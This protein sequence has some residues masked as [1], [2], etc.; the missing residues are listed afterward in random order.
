M[1]LSDIVTEVELAVN[2]STFT[3]DMLTGYINDTYREVV[4]RCLVPD[5]KRV[6]VVTT[7]NNAYVSL[8]TLKSGFSGVLSRVY[9]S[10][11][12]SLR[13]FNKLEFL[14]DLNGNLTTSG[15]LA[16]VALEGNTLWYADIPSI[17]EVLTVI[18]Y[19]LPDLLVNDNDVP[20]Y[21]PDFLHRQIL[22][23]GA[24]AIA[25]DYIEGGIEG[26]KVN[27]RSRLLSMESGVVKFREWLGKNRKHYI[28]T[29]GDNSIG[30]NVLVHGVPFW[31]YL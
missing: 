19:A 8:S 16:A 21:I 25:W 7:T 23:N 24:A 3:S 1:V 26:L 5:L 2:D 12:N 15:E 10:D 4:G 18:Y 30:F 13:I 22:V 20:S 31:R 17:P 29:E 6:D 9:D 28:S 11:G 14:S 27:A